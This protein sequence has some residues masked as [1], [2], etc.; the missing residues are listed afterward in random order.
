M[1][2]FIGIDLPDKMKQNL[3]QLQSELRGYGIKGSWKSVANLHIT[4]EFLGEL[5]TDAIPVL[6]N[7]LIKVASNHKPFKLS[8]KGLGAFPSFKKPNILWSALG[9]NL[10]QLHHLRNELH[11]ELIKSGYR[12]E[13]RPFKPHITLASRPKLEAVNLGDFH[14]KK[15]G[16][17]TVE[18]VTLFESRHINGKLTYIDMFRVNLYKT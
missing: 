5:E 17:F 15:I 9:E 3:F 13:E 4:L 14:A 6:T 8:V 1:R 2:L 7:S 18:D 12:L 16:E 10:T 11:A